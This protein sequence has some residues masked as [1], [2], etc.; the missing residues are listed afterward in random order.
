MLKPKF[1]TSTKLSL[2]FVFH[3]VSVVCHWTSSS[4]FFSRQRQPIGQML[5]FPSWKTLTLS[6]QG[7]VVFAWHTN[8]CKRGFGCYRICCAFCQKIQIPQG[9]MP[10]F[11]ATFVTVTHHSL[12]QFVSKSDTNQSTPGKWWFCIQNSIE[13]ICKRLIPPWPSPTWAIS[14]QRTLPTDSNSFTPP[15]LLKFYHSVVRYPWGHLIQVSDFIL[16]L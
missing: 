11:P 12:T 2:I 8:I 3:Q 16:F 6:L 10:Q 13:F 15:S 7:L 14:I 5:H 4:R 9:K 1:S